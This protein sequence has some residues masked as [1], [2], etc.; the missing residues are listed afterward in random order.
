MKGRAVVRVNPSQAIK[1][2][3][4]TVVLYM[5]NGSKCLVVLTKNED[6]CG[7]RDFNYSMHHRKGN[8]EEFDDLLAQLSLVKRGW[9]SKK[10]KGE[11]ADNPFTQAKVKVH[12]REKM[13]VVEERDDILTRSGIS[14]RDEIAKC[15]YNE[16]IRFLSSL[17]VVYLTVAD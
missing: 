4:T 9:G 5:K 3:T 7:S 8:E 13:I 6:Y 1:E 2:N 11:L 15:T 14:L 12:H 10:V 16:L 17:E